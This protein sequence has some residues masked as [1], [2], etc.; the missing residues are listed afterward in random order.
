MR[1]RHVLA[2]QK[3]FVVAAVSIL[4][5]SGCAGTASLPPR[6]TLPSLPS[7]G[8]RP[9]SPVMEPPAP[10]PAIPTGVAMIAPVP[11]MAPP[12]VDGASLQARYGRP[13]FVRRDADTELWRYDGSDCAVFF[14]LYRDG[15]ALKIRYSESM[16]RGMTMPADPK[17]VESLNAH[18]GAMS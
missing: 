13:D 4:L 16:P 15:G 18:P 2:R 17:C 1:L 10:M 9:V 8:T 3:A 7:F 14:F 11:V 5:L 12:P 6:L